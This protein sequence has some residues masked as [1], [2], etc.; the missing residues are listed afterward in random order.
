MEKSLDL[1][2]AGAIAQEDIK[3][4]YDNVDTIKVFRWLVANNCAPALAATFLRHQLLPTIHLRVGTG[5]SVI[6]NRAR[7][8]LTGSRLAGQL[9]RIPVQDS[10][11]KTLPTL[12]K[13]AWT[14]GD[15]VLV[16]ATFVDN[17]V[18]Y[19]VLL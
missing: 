10:L 19:G 5:H 1:E 14:F 17:F 2:S 6:S 16:A 15:I 18:L 4:H 8:T 12:T 7:G 3:Q 11:R 13:L 9:G